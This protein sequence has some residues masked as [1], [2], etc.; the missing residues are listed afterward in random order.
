MVSESLAQLIKSNQVSAKIASIRFSGNIGDV[1]Q[2]VEFKKNA[3]IKEVTIEL[4]EPVLIERNRAVCAKRVM[5]SFDLS[6]FAVNL[7]F[8]SYEDLIQFCENYC[9]GLPYF[10]KVVTWSNATN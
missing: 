5:E 8:K 9:D 6:H 2:I 3:L 4:I 7:G 1:C 10:G